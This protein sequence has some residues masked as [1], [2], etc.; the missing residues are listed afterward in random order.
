VGQKK[1][2]WFLAS[3][4]GKLTAGVIAGGFDPNDHA[5]MPGRYPNIVIYGCVVGLV[6]LLINR[7][8]H[9]ADGRSE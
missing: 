1:G 6:L 5:A 9:A 7:P 4:L 8:V 2:V 3:S